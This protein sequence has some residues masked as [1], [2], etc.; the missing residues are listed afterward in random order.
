MILF[1]NSNYPSLA[2]SVASH[3]APFA[4]HEMASAQAVGRLG[5]GQP[6][7]ILERPAQAKGELS[8]AV[9]KAV[10]AQGSFNAWGNTGQR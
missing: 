3:K 4:G 10:G 6:K 5:V 1:L 8:G 7:R 2:A 9:G